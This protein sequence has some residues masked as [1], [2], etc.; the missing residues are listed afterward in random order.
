MKNRRFGPARFYKSALM[1]ALPVM[2]QSL[3]QNLVSL[4]DSFMV[5]GLGDVKMSGVNIAGQIMFVFTILLNTICI[6]GGIYMTQFFGANN[7][8][9]MRQS[10]C[11]KIIIAAI[12]MCVYIPVCMVFPRRILS[13]MVVGNT[14]SQAIIDVGVR[15]MFL[16]GF[17]GIPMAVSNIIAASLREIGNVKVPLIISISAALI[18]TALNGVLIYGAFGIPRLEVAGAAYATIIARLFEMIAYLIYVNVRKQPFT[19]QAGDLL[20]IDRKLIFE[21]LRKGAPVFCSEML[22]AMSETITSAM[23]NGRGGADVVSGMSAG[24]AIA[25]LYFIAFSGITTATSIIIGRSLGAGKLDQARREKDWLLYGSFVFGCIVMLIGFATMLLVP[26]VFGKLSPESQSICRS[27][28][29]WMSVLMPAWVYENAQFAIAR[30][31]GDT[32]LSIVVDG[33]CTVV[34]EIPGIILLALFT[35]IGPVTMYIIVKCTD[36]VRV[37]FSHFWLK[38]ENWVRNLTLSHESAPVA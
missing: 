25:N 28:V 37:L 24:F 21:I 35:T 3:I 4:I 8:R 23:Y 5:S 27:M 30:A 33:A 32:M 13:L 38:K 17:I 16:M 6:T 15:Y 11:Y 2:A 26:V 31:G 34:I 29:F 36:L 9:G 19:L 10:L 14:Q 20:H 12:S 22:W 1:L 7:E 18:N